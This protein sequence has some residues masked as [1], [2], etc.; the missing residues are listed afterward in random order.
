MLQK[1]L[2]PVRATASAAAAAQYRAQ[3]TGRTAYTYRQWEPPRSDPQLLTSFIRR[4]SSPAQLL[5]IVTQHQGSVNAIH[6]AAAFNRTVYL[7]RRPSLLASDA[8]IINNQLLPVLIKELRVCKSMLQARGIA[9]VLHAMGSLDVR[10]RELL[11]DLAAAAEPQLGQFTTQGLAN[12]LW[13]LARCGFQAPARWMDVCVGSCQAKLVQF[14]PQELSITLWSLSRLK[15]KLSADTHSNFLRWALSILYQF[16]PHSL[17]LLAY[18]L[19]SME[20]RP[21]PE[22]VTAFVKALLHPPGLARF[23]PQGQCQ[24]LWALGR[25]GYTPTPIFANTVNSFMLEPSL[26]P[27]YKPIDLSTLVYALV[28]LSLPISDALYKAIMSKWQVCL[29]SLSSMQLA[30]S[31]WAFAHLQLGLPQRQLSTPAIAKCLTACYISMDRFNHRDLAMLAWGMATLRFQLPAT[32]LQSMQWRM[33]QVGS[34][35]MPQEVSCTMW[36]LA[37]LGASPSAGL[38]VEFFAATDRRLSS[39][40]PQELSNMIWALAK[41]QHRPDKA[42]VDE[43]MRAAF[44]RLTEF[45]P[46][47]LGNTTWA[48]A[49]LGLRPPP[50]WLYAF[51]KAAAPQLSS[52]RPIDLIVTIQALRVMNSGP[53]G[54]G[55]QRVAEFVDAAV[56]ELQ[57]RAGREETEEK[58]Q[59]PVAGQ[60]GHQ[61]SVGQQGQQGQWVQQNWEVQGQG[62]WQR[63]PVLTK[64]QR[65]MAKAQQHQ[66]MMALPLQLAPVNGAVHPHTGPSQAAPGPSSPPTRHIPAPTAGNQYLPASR[67]VLGPVVKHIPPAQRLPARKALKLMAPQPSDQPLELPPGL[68]AALGPTLAPDFPSHQLGRPASSPLLRGRAGDSLLPSQPPSLRSPSPLW[69]MHPRAPGWP[70]SG[71]PLDW[72]GQP[73][74]PPPVLQPMPTMRFSAAAPP[75]GALGQG[76]QGQ[77]HQPSLPDQS[78]PDQA[79]GH[80]QPA[81]M[82]QPRQPPPPPP[83]SNQPPQS[84]QSDQPPPPPQSDQPPP[85]PKS[86]QP[87]PPPTSDQPPQSYQPP[88]SAQSAQPPQPGSQGEAAGASPGSSPHPGPAQPGLPDLSLSVALAQSASSPGQSSSSTLGPGPPGIR[89]PVSWPSP[90]QPLQP[91]LP[92]SQL[93]EEGLWSCRPGA[94][95]QAQAQ[96]QPA[97]LPAPHP[98]ALTSPPPQALTPQQ[99]QPSLQQQQQPQP[100]LAP[101]VSK[102]AAESHEPLDPLHQSQALPGAPAQQGVQPQPHPRRVSRRGAQAGQAASQAPRLGGLGQSQQQPEGDSGAR[103]AASQGHLVQQPG[104]SSQSGELAERSNDNSDVTGCQPSNSSSSHGSSSQG[105]GHS[106]SLSSHTCRLSAAVRASESGLVGARQVALLLTAASHRP[107]PSQGGRSAWALPPPSPTT[108]PAQPA[109]TTPSPVSTLWPPSTSAPEHWAGGGGTTAAA[110]AGAGAGAAVPDY[111]APPGAA[112]AAEATG[113]EGAAGSEAAAAAGP[114]SPPVRLGVVAAAPAPCSPSSLQLLR[115]LQQGPPPSQ[116]TTLAALLALGPEGE[117]QPWL[118]SSALAR[119]DCPVQAAGPEV[120]GGEEVG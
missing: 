49:V 53:Q 54:L 118:D 25:M 68:A 65:Q 56:A 13:A 95:A 35:F 45:T 104:M 71:P 30:N 110:A 47:G 75:P 50:A 70:P 58:T 16:E 105:S 5:E 85:P 81:D 88:Q 108:H 94:E 76:L 77:M 72:Q 24:V 26:L 39:F 64:V 60:Q 112:V 22:W 33:E 98:A 106:S 21:S 89:P 18:S 62:Q 114:A 3:L 41:V 115:Q 79:E 100:S 78:L 74:H 12:M 32:F 27:A 20:Q 117:P 1:R 11:Q 61:A 17:V 101:T 109:A 37:R 28:Q 86:E 52:M 59:R 102:A 8:R 44:H 14:S 10:E 46:Q 7:Y 97:G 55:L 29:S 31:V 51:V 96:L 43:F 40:K 90:A 57:G 42:W 84:V 73:H 111:S 82:A 93:P 80:T 67:L 92:P 120:A 87:P 103:G 63:A 23:T 9:T 99:Q 69:P 6:I 116:P 66:A 91:P 19:G 38:L 15:C 119:F 107:V 113:A 36:A 4:A 2:G 48:L 34:E 83:P